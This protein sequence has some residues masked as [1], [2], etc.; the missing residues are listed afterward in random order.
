MQYIGI[1]IVEAVPMTAEEAVN[2]GY[3][4]GDNAGDGYEVTYPEGYKSWCPKDVFEKHNHMLNR[5]FVQTVL[6]MISMDWKERF[7]AEYFQ[8]YSRYHLLDNAIKTGTINTEKTPERIYV[9]QLEILEKYVNI[10]EER[11]ELEG[12][13]LD[14]DKFKKDHNY[15]YSY[16]EKIN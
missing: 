7:L 15:I 5:V 8:A 2:H 3:R 11:A 14:Y 12:I 9:L 13:D 16:N 6:P 1:K 4:I 10:L